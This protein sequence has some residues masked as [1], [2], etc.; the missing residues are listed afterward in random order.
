MAKVSFLYWLPPVG[1]LPS[2]VWAAPRSSSP[3]PPSAASCATSR[4]S[5]PAWP[6]SVRGNVL[7]IHWRHKLFLEIYFL[8]FFNKEELETSIKEFNKQMC[9][10]TALPEYKALGWEFT[11]LLTQIRNILRNFRVL[12]WSSYS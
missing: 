6:Q 9:P 8:D 10:S 5:T 12:L 7:K 4:R 3:P 11:K 2:P 1:W